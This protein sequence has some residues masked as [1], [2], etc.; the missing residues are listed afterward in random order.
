MVKNKDLVILA[1]DG[2]LDNM[3]DK[4]ILHCLKSSQDWM[5]DLIEDHDTEKAAVCLAERASKLSQDPT[6]DSPFAQ[7]A[8]Q[9]NKN[10]PGGKVDDIT[11]IVG[12][13]RFID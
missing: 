3:F 5:S 4:D 10:F 2:I 9:H 6:Y 1:S 7:H 11:V 8:R 13:V 12:Q